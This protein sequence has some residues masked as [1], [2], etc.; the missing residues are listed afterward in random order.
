LRGRNQLD[1]IRTGNAENKYSMMTKFFALLLSLFLVM[2]LASLA[3]NLAHFAPDKMET[4]LYGAAYYPE[5]MPYDR[6]DQDVQLMQQAGISVVRMGESSWG[7]WEPQDGNFEFAWM[8]RVI[9]RMQKAGIKV[10]L[11]TPTYSVPAW[12]YKEHPEIFITR[13]GGETI[14]FGYRQNTDLLNP[15]YRFYCE[16][17]IRKLLEHYK[18]NPAVIGWQIDN[19]TSSGAAANHDVQVGFVEY[20]KK[21]FHTVDELNKD[22]LLN[23]WGQR[24][25]DWTEIPPEEGIINP[26]WKLEWQRY[27]QWMTTDFLSWQASIVN[28]YKRAD[29]FI[30]H[31]LAGP[32]RP[33]VNEHAISDAM[34]IMAVNPYHGTQDQFDGLDS[35]HAGDYTRSLKRTNYLVTETNAQTIGW[36][37]KEQFPPY[38]GQLRL[39]VYT[40]LSSGANMVEYWH[41]HSIHNGQEMYWKGVLSH[42]LEPNRAYAEVSRIAHEL[43]RIGPEIV[44]L[45]RSNKVAI[46]YSADSYY[47][48][49][50][51]KFSDKVNYRTVMD[52]MYAVL[53][54]SN[55]GVDFVFPESTNFGD[56]RVILVPPLYVASDDL[57]NRLVDYVHNGGYL[58]MGFKSGFTNEYDTARWTMAPGPLRK[59]AGL[60]Y[61][62]F[63]SLAKPLALKD[64][65]FKAGA[66]NTVSEWAEML[67]PEGAEALAYYDHPFFGK[68]P[69]IT[70]NRYVN[71][72]LTYEG[73]VLSDALQT[74]VVLDVLRMTGLT[75][76]DQDL[77]ASIRVKHGLNGKG[78]VIHYYLNYSSDAQS[79]NYPYKSGKDLLT[80]SDIAFAQS[81]TLKPWDLVIIQEK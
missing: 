68:Y 50:F 49:E 45:K 43:K 37:S 39:D 14:T 81:V 70:R 78:K 62:E 22:W 55:V 65:P 28:Q 57:L 61:Q 51:M 27:Q 30:T 33:V 20:L 29:Q 69:A 3:E 36:D 44:D 19:E 15:T 21:K 72:T 32:P 18:N 53:Y 74:K 64:D 11:G 7:L 35:T 17:V 24:L 13:F 54:R 16:R 80:S 34:D 73:T 25:N 6:L 41:W 42:D 23:Y 75:G 79:F 71:G 76:P 67:I 9:D 4:V 31:D 47:G 40:H 59:A 2:P 10:I 12:M 5:Y 48:I 46:L 56:Y 52:Q 60:R 8:D 58:V 38:D 1:G 66:G 77:P 63:S 26:G